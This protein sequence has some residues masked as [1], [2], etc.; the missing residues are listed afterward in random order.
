MECS[1]CVWDA[2]KNLEN[3]RKHGV[4]FED[5]CCVF[6]DP[7]LSQEP[8]DRDYGEERWI[9]IGRVDSEILVVVYTERNGTARIISARKAKR[10]EEEIYYDFY[11]RPR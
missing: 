5:A 2:R 4:K 1:G 11:G 3:F 6:N 7:S 9:A 8:D 10:N